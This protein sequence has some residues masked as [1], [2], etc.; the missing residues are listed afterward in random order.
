MRYK[1]N[2]HPKKRNLFSQ[3]KDSVVTEQPELFRKES[4]HFILKQARIDTSNEQS[5]AFGEH[6][7]HVDNVG[8][9]TFNN[10]I[11]IN[12]NRT[13][14][15]K[16]AFTSNHGIRESLHGGSIAERSVYNKPQPRGEGGN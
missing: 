14:V 11:R 4:P 2:S 13:V 12:I 16:E 1:Q 6:I 5:A 15:E 7:V 10:G 9:I 8:T 3:N